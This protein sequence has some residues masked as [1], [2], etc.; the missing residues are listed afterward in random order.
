MQRVIVVDALEA[1]QEHLALVD[2]RVEDAIAIDVGV[3]DQIG[4][5]G[6]DDL[7][8]DHRHAER[9]DERG[10]LHERVGRVSLA[11]VIGVLDDDDPV[12][13]GLT[14]VVR[15]IADAFGDPDPAVAVDVE[16]GRVAQH[17][18]GGPERHLEAL[19]HL[20]EVQRNPDGLGR[21]GRRALGGGRA[22]GR[23]LWRRRHGGLLRH[24]GQQQ[25]HQHRVQRRKGKSTHMS[26]IHGF[27]FRLSGPAH[28][29]GTAGGR[30]QELIC[31]RDEVQA[32]AERRPEAIQRAC[33]PA[34]IGSVRGVSRDHRNGI[35]RQMHGAVTEPDVRMRDQQETSTCLGVDRRDLFAEI[36]RDRGWDHGGSSAGRG[37]RP[38]SP[39]RRGSG[40]RARTGARAGGR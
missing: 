6:D 40:R 1:G 33:Q 12:A 4:R 31:A 30:A 16:V 3:D 23:G 24:D 18:R 19:R 35:G 36:T 26:P 8:V 15:T 5:L 37:C 20:K 7:V 11:V 32:G 29:S 22:L 9:G 2:R 17:R 28:G 21:R 39:A 34:A 25:H 38:R 13:F 10:L 14:G 27:S